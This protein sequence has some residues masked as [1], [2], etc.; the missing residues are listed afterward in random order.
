MEEK[1]FADMIKD[2]EMGRL[3][4]ILMCVYKREAEADCTIHKEG[5][6]T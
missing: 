1:V 3:S 4:W 2:L 6:M 5:T